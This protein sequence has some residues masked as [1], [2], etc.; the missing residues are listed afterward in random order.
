[1]S[2]SEEQHRWYGSEKSQ[3]ARLKWFGHVRRIDDVNIKRRMLRMKLPGKRKRGR[4]KMRF[5]DAVR[6][7]G[8]GSG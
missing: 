3:D 2:T 5:M 8:L 4:P 7:R 6:E 1:M